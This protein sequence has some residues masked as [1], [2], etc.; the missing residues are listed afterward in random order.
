MALFRRADIFITYC[1]NVVIGV[2]G[3][4]RNRTL[5]VVLAA[6]GNSAIVSQSESHQGSPADRDG[7]PSAAETDTKLEHFFILSTS[8]RFLGRNA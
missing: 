5:V 1:F 4:C 7:T 8:I 2:A 3:R 6:N